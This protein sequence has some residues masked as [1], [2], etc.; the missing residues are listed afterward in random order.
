MG[1]TSLPSVLN[2]PGKPAWMLM[3][4]PGPLILIY[5][6]LTLPPTVGIPS[7][8]SLPTENLVLAGLFL[9]HYAY[10]AVIGP[11][12]NPSMSPIHPLILVTG[13]YFQFCNASSIAGWLAGYGRV[14]R[15]SWHAGHSN[16]FT[17]GARM[18]L[19]F[20]LW[21]VG[22]AGTM[23]HDDV[24]RELR[25]ASNKKQA[26]KQKSE[27]AK[28]DQR[29]YLLPTAGLF[30]FVLSPHYFCEWLEWAGFWLMCGGD[31]V[32]ARNFL[33]NEVATMLPRALQT[34][35][36]YVERF[37]AERVGSRKAVIP[38]LV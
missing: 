10:R 35:R 24:L 29:V 28:G 7:F 6:F 23:Y 14:T 37:G 15:E 33:V 34:R 16:A 11:L 36:W 8:L 26:E 31:C 22:F 20:C 18:Q 21:A 19:G 27:G 9:T 4:L 13:W 38:G 17:V 32:P 25:R 1:K 2:L 3:E 12:L 30:H 5:T